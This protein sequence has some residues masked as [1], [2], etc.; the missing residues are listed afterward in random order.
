M[1]EW[2]DCTSKLGKKLTWSGIYNSSWARRIGKYKTWGNSMMKRSEKSTEQTLEGHN[3]LTS[4]TRWLWHS[5]LLKR[6]YNNKNNSNW[7]NKAIHS[8]ELHPALQSPTIL[9]CTRSHWNYLTSNL[10]TRNCSRNTQHIWLSRTVCKFSFINKSININFCYRSKRKNQSKR[11]KGTFR[12]C[13]NSLD[14]WT[15]ELS[16]IFKAIKLIPWLRKSKKFMSRKRK[17]WKSNF[18]KAGTLNS[19]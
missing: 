11:R 4:S 10:F 12:K 8:S 17:K 7:T 3:S 5:T 14:L 16:I 19:L 18:R 6:D 15:R 9:H 1:A 2:K 13:K